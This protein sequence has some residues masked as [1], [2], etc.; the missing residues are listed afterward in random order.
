M[1]GERKSPLRWENSSSDSSITPLSP[2][3]SCNKIGCGGMLEAVGDPEEG[4]N[5]VILVQ[6]PLLSGPRA[7][8]IPTCRGLKVVLYVSAALR[9]SIRAVLHFKSLSEETIFPGML[10]FSS[11]SA[12]FRA[13][14]MQFICQHACVRTE[15]T[16][17]GALE[18]AAGVGGAV[19]GSCEPDSRL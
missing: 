13:E 14:C 1:P 9:H 11:L 3:E 8:G 19:W 4:L 6:D 18:S 10:H 5:I 7:R 2:L 16:E 17:G 15:T 12:A